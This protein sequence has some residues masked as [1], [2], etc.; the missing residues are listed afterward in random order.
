MAS[1]DLSFRCNCRNIIAAFLVRTLSDCFPKHSYI[2]E[3]IVT[4]QI[5]YRGSIDTCER[6]KLSEAFRIN[7]T[8][9]RFDLT[10]KWMNKFG[11]LASN[12]RCNC[13]NIIAALL[14]RPISDC[15]P[16]HSYITET[17]V[18]MQIDYRGRIDACERLHRRWTH[19]KYSKL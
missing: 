16:K 4:M 8:L 10:T 15:F 6:R 17:I 2:S 14:V 7:A 13:R 5:D 12:V 3:T 18:T 1:N 11:P 19:A 9:I